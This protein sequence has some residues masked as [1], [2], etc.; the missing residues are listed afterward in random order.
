M[1]DGPATR[2]SVV[3]RYFTRI[4]WT[5]IKGKLCEDQCVLQ[6]S[7]KICVITIAPS[8]PL[9][10]CEQITNVNFQ[11]STKVNRL[12]NKVSGKGK[13]GAQHLQPDS[14]LC[15]V[16]CSSGTKYSLYSCVRGKLVEVNEELVSKPHLMLEK[17]E[18]E[19]YLAVVLPKLTENILDGR[20]TKE[21]YDK[22]LEDRKAPNGCAESNG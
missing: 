22:L 8:H 18:T 7:N 19:G 21:E 1:A 4:F 2:P 11:V 5:D 13:K 6:H 3:D 16:T 10:R 20:L 14:L 9:L 15:E 17:P 12:D